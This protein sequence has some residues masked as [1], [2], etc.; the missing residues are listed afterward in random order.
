[1]AV[2]LRSPAEYRP[3]LEEALRRADIPAFFARGT[4]RP[5]PAGRALLALLACAAEHLSARRFAEYISLAQVPDPETPA[6][7]E[8]RFVPP[9][10]DLLPG[11]P[12]PPEGGDENPLPADPEAMAVIDGTVRAP[13]RWEAL[14]VEASVIGGRERWARRLGGLEAELRLR[15]A[16]LAGAE[17]ETRAALLERQLADLDHLRAFALPLID[18]LAALPRA[19]TWGEWLALL[20]ELAV[21]ALR[22]PEAVL[23]TLA[24]LEPMAPIGPVELD[25]VQ[26][27]LG[28]RL[29]ELVVPPPRRRHGAVLIAPAENARGLAF[30]LVLVPGLA[31]RLFPRKIVEDPILLDEHRRRL[32]VPGLAMQPAR[33]AAERLAL[34]LAVGAARRRVVLSYPRVDVEHG[35][36]RVPSFYGLEALRAA[37]GTLTGFDALATR[38]EREAG[39]RLG[40]PAPARP[41]DAIDEAEYDL[42]LLAPL[43]H[44][45]PRMTAGT[46]R[47]LLTANPHLGRALRA[48]AR[49]WLRRWTPADGLVD[50]DALAREALAAHQLGARS[51]SPTALQH[52]AVCPYR[53]LLQAI[54]RLA[55]REEPAAAETLDPLTR[56]ALFHEVQFAVLTRLRAEDRLP[57]RPATLERAL[58]LLDEALDAAA[59]RHEEMLWPAIRRVWQDGI[60]G[61]RAD[62][63]EWLRR[64]AEVDDGWRPY[65]FELGFGLAGRERPEGDPASVPEPV[66]VAGGLL[67]RGSIDLVERHP[68]GAF[69]ATDH[70]TGKVRAERGVVVGGGE[71][72]QPVL[73]A[74]ACERLLGGPVE[75]GRL[76]YCTADGGYEERLVPLDEES[77]AS[78]AAVAGAVGRA[79]AEGFLPAAP[80]M[81]ACA[82]C[83]YRAVCGPH[84]EQRTSRKPPERLAHLQHLR[85]LR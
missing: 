44:A 69:R 32:A 20:R 39:G 11:A 79:L 64:L 48:R 7:R 47:Y 81:G 24:E 78:A 23:A 12:A 50:P 46:A 62:L 56:G 30:D 3:H 59:A 10:P 57:I 9:E 73:Y 27:V 13:W 6:D 42:A 18:R 63:R 75:A 21:V 41:A 71:V 8:A 55:P 17:E 67:L 60:D 36:P 16:A 53:F 31:E 22:H 52:F 70:K 51:F 82:W 34:R 49:R 4:A 61:V 2:L 40:W 19:A 85:S 58:V 15:L 5:D 84:E 33:G 26:L 83:D 28:P 68:R 29:R 37:E 74:L 35:R 66:P 54:H 65:R 25:E 14:L 77:R 43:L 80:K 45:D 72:L 38:S 76:Y 1:M